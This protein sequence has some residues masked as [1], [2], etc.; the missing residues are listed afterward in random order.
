MILLRIFKS[1]LAAPGCT[2]F[3]NEV[4]AKVSIEKT[5]YKIISLQS[6]SCRSSFSPSFTEIIQKVSGIQE[7][8]SNKN[9]FD[10]HLRFY[11]DWMRGNV[12]KMA[13]Y[14]SAEPSCMGLFYQN[15]AGTSRLSLLISAIKHWC[16]QNHEC[17]FADASIPTS[18]ILFHLSVKADSFNTSHLLNS[19]IND[20]CR[21]PSESVSLMRGVQP[22]SPC[23]PQ[24]KVELGSPL[25][26]IWYCKLFIV[27]WIR[28]RKHRGSLPVLTILIIKWN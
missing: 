19:Q 7:T 22:M 13:C 23:S 5:C 10:R 17:M 8:S 25:C 26:G 18:S 12:W 16:A 15:T 2:D 1:P 4:K 14:V 6:S 21:Q 9:V 20:E 3:W 11:Q 28:R 27:F 24:R